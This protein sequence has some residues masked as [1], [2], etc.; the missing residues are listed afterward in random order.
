VIHL[1]RG[2]FWNNGLVIDDSG[3]ANRPVTLTTYGQGHRPIITNPGSPSNWTKGI[4]IDANWVVV[5]GLLIRNVYDAGIHIENGANHNVIRNVE[6]TDAGGG[7]GIDGQH[8]LV[9]RCYIHDL[10]MIVNT[11]G[12]NDDYGAVGVWL[13]NS[14]NEVS[15]N[16]FENCKAPSYDYGEDGGAVEWWCQGKTIK[17]G[18]VH[19]NY[20]TGNNGFFEVGSNKGMV[21]DAVVAYN[22]SHNDDWLGLFG[23]SGSF[24][25]RLKGFRIENNTVIQDAPSSAWSCCALVFDGYTSPY[26]VMVRNNIFYLQNWN[27]S[28]N[29]GFGRAHNIYAMKGKAHLGIRLGAGDMIV[30]PQFVD[31]ENGDY[32]LRPN[33]PA[34]DAGLGLG[35]RRD[36]N[37]QVVP[38]GRAVDIGAF[39]YAGNA[40]P[41]PTDT[42]TN[43][44]SWTPTDTPTQQP[45]DTPTWQPTDTPTVQ[46]TNTPTDTP[47]WQPTDTSTVQPMN[48]PTAAPTD[49]PTTQPTAVA[50]LAGS[51][52]I[53]DD[54]DPGF[55]TVRGQDSWRRYDFVNGEHYGDSHVYNRQTGIGADS[56]TWTFTVPTPGQYQVYAWWWAGPWRPSDVPYTINHRDGATTVRVSQRHNGGQWN[57]LGTYNFAGDGS[58]MVHDDVSSSGFDIAAD[59]VRLVRVGSANRAPEPQPTDTP[60]PTATSTPTPTP[61]IRD[62]II[63]DLDPAFS[64]TSHQDPWNQFVYAAGQHYGNSHF[65]NRQLG[66]GGDVATWTFEAPAPGRYM[67]YA[68]WWAGDWRPSDV[69][70]TIN[71]RYG[72]TTVH[73]DQRI[74]GGAWN[75]LGEFRFSGQASIVIS[76]D[77]SVGKDIVADAIKLVHVGP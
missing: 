60:L 61:V 10:H 12:G 16:R 30:D 67:V 76:D 34:I 62:L 35:H 47:T 20:S 68:W 27:L 45:T 48:T 17:G 39:E 53:I 70:Y 66:T 32:R 21:M 42:P 72:S 64:V 33:S 77:A 3:S 41:V 2:S 28:Y 52:L 8:N 36:H 15:Y 57:P 69:P 37:G 11:P 56:A 46:P 6:I 38:F 63:D 65:Y 29:G 4:E 26:A 58:V 25:T 51:D 1:R 43:S 18:Y 7:V 19:H 13:F 5:E 54:T 22:V 44:P 31:R 74:G 73:M 9:T 49:T 23:T 50:T 75:L 71:H 24:A 40:P 59:A 55:S 14:N